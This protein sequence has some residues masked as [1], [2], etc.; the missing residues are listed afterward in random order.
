MTV[1]RVLIVEENQKIMEQLRDSLEAEG[2][3][4]EIA[5]SLE[6]GAKILKERRM[7]LLIIDPGPE[8]STLNRTYKK[9][10]EMEVTCPVISL[11]PE[12]HLKEYRKKLGRKIKFYP[13]E[14]LDF[15]PLVAQ[16]R[17]IL[18]KE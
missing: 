13:Q 9:V 3:D 18:G 15:D 10:K 4:T 5:L 7:D 17:K 16:A 11:V 2:F 8:K 1:P 12:K 6:L 14:A